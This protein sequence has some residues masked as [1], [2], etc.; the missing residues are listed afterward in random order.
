MKIK[1]VIEQSVEVVG[2][3]FS[4]D[5]H[6]DCDF[7]GYE[8]HSCKREVHLN[9]S[10]IPHTKNLSI[11]FSNVDYFQTSKSFHSANICCLEE[12]GFKSPDDHTDEWLLDQSQSESNDHLFFRFEENEFIR[13][14]SESV[15]LV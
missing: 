5:L 6:N 3:D 1:F 8:Y 7:L 14:H 13:I 2:P 12:I 9:F 4:Y 15:F 11:V 10:F